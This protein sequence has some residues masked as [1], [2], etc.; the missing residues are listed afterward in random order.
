[1]VLAPEH[2]LVDALVAEQWPADV[3]ARWT[4]GAATPAEAVAAYRATIAAK[5]DLE[6]QENKAKTGVFLGAYA[7]NPANGQRIPVFIADYVLMGYGT[8]AIMAVPGGDQRDWDFAHEFGLPIIETV[9]GG[10]ISQAAYSGD[11]EVVNSDYLN[12]LSVAS[13]KEA[14][15]E[16]LVADGRGQARVEY[17]LR[18]WLFARQRYWGEPFPIVYDADGR[19][20]P[21]PESALPVELPDIPDYAPVQ[22]DPDDADSEPSP[23]LGKATDWVQ[24]RTGSRRRLEALHPRHQRDAAVG[25]QLLVRAALHRPVQQRRV[26]RQGERGLLDGPA[27]GRARGQR[28]RRCRPLRRRCRA[29]RAAPAVCAVLAQGALR[30]RAHQLARAVSA[31]W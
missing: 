7:T 21:L 22:F 20:H 23:P 1:M 3:D 24:C 19:A 15:T 2:E 6:R 27:T 11:G 30:P 13:A 16:R 5:S 31:G 28:P 18:D 12:G 29:C 17:K 14:I 25:G 4:F 26:V 9:A 8:G 10:D